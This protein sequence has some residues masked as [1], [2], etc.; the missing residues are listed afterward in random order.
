MFALLEIGSSSFIIEGERKI[1]KQIVDT[2]H[3]SKHNQENLELAQ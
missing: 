1:Y 2:W 3:C